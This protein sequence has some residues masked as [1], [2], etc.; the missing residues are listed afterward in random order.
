MEQGR[1]EV[2]RRGVFGDLREHLGGGA[3]ARDQAELTI[4]LEEDVWR[5]RGAVEPGF[6][7]VR[8]GCFAPAIATLAGAISRLSTVAL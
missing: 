5:Q 7:Y 6:S 4:S 2:D 3:A 1:E 8:A